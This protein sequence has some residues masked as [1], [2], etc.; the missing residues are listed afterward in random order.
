MNGLFSSLPFTELGV[1]VGATLF[2]G[3]LIGSIALVVFFL[4]RLPPT[5]FHP[6]HD[7]RFM[8]D[9]HWAIRRCGIIVKNIIGVI[10]VLLGIVMSLP[11]MPGQGL[12]TLLVGMM[13]VDFPGKRALE[14]K[15]IRQPRF[16]RVIN[17]LR[18]KFSKAPLVLE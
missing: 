6:S 14:Y 3:T 5:Y 15:I 2:V 12:L 11:G 18:K 1:I 10:L 7:R 4:I 17:K 9:H 8:D 13:L 16:L